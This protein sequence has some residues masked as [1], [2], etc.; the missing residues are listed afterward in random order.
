MSDEQPDVVVTESLAPSGWAEPSMPADRGGDAR[1]DLPNVL[2]AHPEIASKPKRKVEAKAIAAPVGGSLGGA[3][4]SFI[5]WL[6]GVLVWHVPSA[7]SS[8][9]DAIA[10]VP[11]PVTALLVIIIPGGLAYVAA[12]LAPH[13][14]RP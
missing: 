7:S 13:T 12:W 2:R 11:W 6:L 3:L 9:G 4:T 14:P 5:L 8:A 10:A 1:D